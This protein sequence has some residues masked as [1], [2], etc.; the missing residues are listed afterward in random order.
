MKLTQH[1]KLGALQSLADALPAL[2]SAIPIAIQWVEDTRVAVASELPAAMPPERTMAI[3]ANIKREQLESQ[4][5]ADNSELA[6]LRTKLAASERRESFLLNE[7]DQ[8]ANTL[9]AVA[10]ALQIPVVNDPNLPPHN[11]GTLVADAQ[12]IMAELKEWR[13]GVRQK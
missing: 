2:A 9:M 6:D 13:T 11:L 1:Q 7:V 10:Q 5:S 3:A 4:V 8:T 12:K